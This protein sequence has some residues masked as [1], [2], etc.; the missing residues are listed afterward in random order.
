MYILFPFFSTESNRF[1]SGG[2]PCFSIFYA[3]QRLSD[4]FATRPVAGDWQRAAP[5]TQAN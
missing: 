4:V 1:S 5:K 2:L 3:C